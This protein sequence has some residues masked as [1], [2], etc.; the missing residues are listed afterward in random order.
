MH[1]GEYARGAYLDPV[2]DRV[3]ER[4]F[5][6]FAFRVMIL[7]MV[8]ASAVVKIVFSIMSYRSFVEL[9]DNEDKS[10]SFKSMEFYDIYGHD[11]GDF[12]KVLNETS[13]E[14]VIPKNKTIIVPTEFEDFEHTMPYKGMSTVALTSTIVTASLVLVHMLRMFPSFE[15]TFFVHGGLLTYPIVY[16]HKSLIVALDTMMFAFMTFFYHQIEH[17]KGANE[18][19]AQRNVVLSFVFGLVLIA[20]LD[21]V[22][23]NLINYAIRMAAGQ[24]MNGPLNKHGD[25]RPLAAQA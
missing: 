5:V 11:E 18:H 6:P 2:S 1:T 21:T 23:R 13:G 19:D 14:M 10:V 25:L 15:R 16:M 24:S 8:G 4:Y 3:D 22:E 12:M 20:L 17:V 9:F 7:I